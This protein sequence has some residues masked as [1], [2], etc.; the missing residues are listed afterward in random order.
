MKISIPDD[1][2]DPLLTMDNVVAKP[3]IG[4]FSRDGYQ[5]QLQF[6]DIF[7]QI[8]GDPAG[9]QTDA[10]NPDVPAMTE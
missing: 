1:Y 8:V 10:V 9:G 5:Y 2:F 4:H 7:D 6:G 3:H